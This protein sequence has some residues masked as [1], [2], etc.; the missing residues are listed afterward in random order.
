MG[1]GANVNAFVP[2]PILPKQHNTAMIK[3]VKYSN[4][5]KPSKP[6]SNVILN[7]EGFLLD[8]YLMITCLALDQSIF[9]TCAFKKS[10]K[11]QGIVLF[12]DS[13]VIVSNT[14][15]F[16]ELVGFSSM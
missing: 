15:N 10:D 11:D 3:F 2:P 12:D 9:F 8:V 13:N 5:R 7:S 4:S 16:S 14:D 1:L 6:I